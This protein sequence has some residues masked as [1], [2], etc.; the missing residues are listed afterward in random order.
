MNIPLSTKFTE[1][2]LDYYLEKFFWKS[3][4]EESKS[5]TF[6]LSITEW[7][8]SEEICFLFSWIRKLISLKINVKIILPFQYNINTCL[9]T[10]DEVNALITDLNYKDNNNRIDRRRRLNLFL[11]GVWGMLNEIGLSDSNFVNIIEGYNVKSRTIKESIYSRQIIPFTV[12]DSSLN[13]E[14]KTYVDSEYIDVLSG[15]RTRNK[16]FDFKSNK[17]IF[18]LQQDIVALL[19]SNNCFSPF[20][21]NIISHII[22][23]E[24]FIN[25]LEH[26]GEEECYF[27][28][29]LNNKWGSTKGKNFIDHFKEEKDVDTL[30]FFKDKPV[31]LQ[32]EKSILNRGVRKDNSVDDH[33]TRET[34]LKKYDQDYR[35]ISY[36]QF[37]FIDFG[38]GIYNTLRESFDSFCHENK[39]NVDL[40]RHSDTHSMILE[41][42]FR[43]E[44]SKNPYER[45]I[46]YSELIP[47]GLYFLIDM[48]RRFKGLLVARSGS[49]KIIY[50]FSDKVYIEKN[51]KNQVQLS[52]SRVYQ[53][54]EAIRNRTM[55]PAFF[56]G[57]MLNIILPERDFTKLKRSS[58]RTDN[59][60]LNKYIF[61]FDINQ[62]FPRE[63]F[64]PMEYTYL[65]MVFIY[66]EAINTLDSSDLHD[67]NK[68]NS[69]IF[70]KIDQKI[71]ELQN[72][73]SVLFIDF[74]F[75]ILPKSH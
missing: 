33:Q 30:D 57:T 15:K 10:T 14:R 59:E 4:T 51:H 52:I 22:T 25:S 49:G 18:E 13:K 24:L 19:T 47:R 70:R 41:Y 38:V 32:K 63:V 16:E 17:P 44:S 66:H 61:N 11:L 39:N 43:M 28:V 36:V 74:E 48:V 2:Q 65:S 42:A 1:N 67:K 31:L 6:D 5:V 50:D 56:N 64:L 20:E 46:A 29:A 12:L 60:I 55:E 68:I 54:K 71:N 9:D 69:F 3:L 40:T 73:S 7:I 8:S 21:S 26:S 58:V 75:P 37:T 62:Q 72:K 35:D 23:K 27:T 45:D 34:N 53:A